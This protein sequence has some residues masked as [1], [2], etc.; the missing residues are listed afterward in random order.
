MLA[1]ESCLSES[2]YPFNDTFII[3][4][5]KGRFT[6]KSNTVPSLP[7]LMKGVAWAVK[8]IALR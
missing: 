4:Y 8:S 6:L 2:E 3:I 5:L 1:D 7:W